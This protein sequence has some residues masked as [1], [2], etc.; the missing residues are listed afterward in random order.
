MKMAQP[1][2][3][4][5]FIFSQQRFVRFQGRSRRWC[6]IL[7]EERKYSPSPQKNIHP[8]C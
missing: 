5:G 4:V 7:F 3:Y 8:K 6:E 2:I 1:S